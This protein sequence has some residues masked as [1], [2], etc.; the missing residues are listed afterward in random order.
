MTD[1]KIIELFFKRDEQAVRLCMTRYG[2]YCHTVAAN[3]LDTPGDA[4]E[5][6]ADAWMDAWNAIPP[7]KAS[8]SAAVFGKA[9][10]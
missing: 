3:I 7:P 5:A 6:V 10:P 2:S 4:E 8:V 9:Y 1:E